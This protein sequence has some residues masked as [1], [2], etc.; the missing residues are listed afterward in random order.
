MRLFHK[1]IAACLAIVLAASVAGC[2]PISL[3][4]EWGYKYEDKTLTKQYDIGMYIYNLYLAYNQAS[5]YAEKAKGYK[6]SES[7]AELKI[8][9][10][11]GKKAVAKDWIKDK[12]EENMLGAIALDYL[13]KKNKVKWDKSAMDSAEKSAK[14]AWEMGPYAAYGYYQPIRD[15]VEKYGV[16]FES[17]AY[18]AA[19]SGVKQ[20]ALFTKLYDKDGV[21]EVSD[22]ELT[23]YFLKNYT[24]YSYIPV[25]LYTSSTDA[26]GN[27]SSKKFSK[28]KIKNIKSELEALAEDISNGDTTFKKASEKCEKDYNATSSDIVTEKVSTKEDLKS[29]NADI[30]EAISKLKNGEAKL[31]VV[32]E[33]GD[34]PI[35]YVAVKNNVKDYVKTQLESERTSILQ[36]MKGDDLTDLLKKT[37]KDL[38]KKDALTV[39]Q[40][41]IDKYPADLFYEKPEETTA[42]TTS[43]S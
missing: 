27:S 7:F 20:Q 33:S 28:K 31:V 9:D 15:A 32:G 11:D 40:G 39:N 21:E 37:G 26:D 41:V 2:V 13:C 1:V 30:S 24:A 8:K 10:D 12:A 38:K 19:K 16:S 23:D 3:S 29:T 25:N 22:K 18:L 5:S 36:N 42:A 14:D 43:A 6:A 35:A 17:Y 4:K 34:S